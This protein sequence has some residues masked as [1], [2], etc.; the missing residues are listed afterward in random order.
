MTDEQQG[1]LA[2]RLLSCHLEMSG[3]SGHACRDSTPLSVCTGV[4]S[5]HAFQ[6]YT[7][8]FNE[9]RAICSY[10]LAR[11]F[12]RETSRM[13]VAL[14]GAAEEAGATLLGL[15]DSLVGLSRGVDRLDAAHR[16]L[17]EQ[18]GLAEA[19]ARGAAGA[20]EA[21]QAQSAASREAVAAAEE[22]FRESRRA[23]EDALALLAAQG[24]RTSQMVARVLGN[25]HAA[26]D[27]AFYAGALGLAL[28]LLPGTVA[29]AL[30]VACYFAE[31]YAL[32]RAGPEISADSHWTALVGLGSARRWLAG[33]GGDGAAPPPLSVDAKWAVRSAF[34]G[35]ALAL[36]S[37]AAR[38]RRAA[39]S[40]IDAAAAADLRAEMARTRRAVREAVELL[41]PPTSPRGG[42]GGTAPLHGPTPETP[43]TAMLPPPG[44]AGDEDGDDGGGPGGAAKTRP[45]SPVAARTRLRRPR[46]N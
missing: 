18:V 2:L 34:A 4:L 42:R 21:A 32:E 10:V 35:L 36:A 9:S 31:R 39:A 45:T 19:A 12:K 41:S 37:A 20:A 29:P 14:H 11:D 6:L 22:S 16:R 30:V 17:H 33:P 40:P 24:Q 25:A 5:E 15:D 27:V 8:F 43:A 13:L 26:G 7:A 44:W 1:R 23:A 38:R 28:T 46:K 3:R